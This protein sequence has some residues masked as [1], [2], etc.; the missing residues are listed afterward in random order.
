M[1]ENPW[2]NLNLREKIRV[3]SKERVV[4]CNWFV[5]HT[6]KYGYFIESEELGS[7]VGFSINLKGIQV[8]LNSSNSRSILVLI[9][10]SNDDWEIFYSLCKD[11]TDAAD[12]VTTVGGFILSIRNRLTRW[13]SMLKMLKVTSMSSQ[14]Q[15]G[16]FSELYFLLHN[17]APKVGIKQALISW[18][19]PDSDKQD[20]LLDNAVVEVKSYRTSKGLRVF[21][22]SAEQL[23]SEKDPL[24][25]VTYALSTV[26][27]GESVSDLISN[28]ES[29]IDSN[30]EMLFDLFSE[31][32]TKYGFIPELPDSSLMCFTVDKEKI[33]SVV[34]EFPKIVSSDISKAIGN[35]KYSVDL[36]ECEDFITESLSDFL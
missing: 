23:Y 18:V 25:L 30:S 22:S 4:E 9:L 26:D 5:D 36:S 14:I 33:Y 17:L 29:M 34:D 10:D 24:F 19:G 6:G 2:K 3:D 12:N 7:E 16:L 35:V 1:Y 31:K 13:Q 8:S 32:L 20:F 11:L 28:I 21:I 27:S 15:M